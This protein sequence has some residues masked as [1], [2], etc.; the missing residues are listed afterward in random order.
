M[1]AYLTNLLRT[2]QTRTTSMWLGDDLRIS[3]KALGHPITLVCVAGLLLNDHLLK[4]LFSSVLTGKLSDF[5]GIFFFPYIIVAFVAAGTL[6]LARVVSRGHP[7]HISIPFDLSTTAYVVTGLVFSLVKLS[8]QAAAGASALLSGLFKLPIYVAPDPSDLIALLALWPSRWL[9]RSVAH[10]R[11]RQ[12]A[13]G[14]I[15][16]LGMAA[17]AVMATSPCLETPTITHLVRGQDGVYAVLTDFGGPGGILISTDRGLGWEYAH[18]DELPASI[19]QASESQVLLPKIE[20]VPSLDGVCYR[21]AGRGQLEA[22]ADGGSTWETIWSISPSRREYM[23]RV[24]SGHGLLL[25][26]GKE[27]DLRANDLIVVGEAEG[28]L[29]LV[30]IGNEGVLRGRLGSVEWERRGVATVEPTPIRGEL[31]D[32]YLPLIIIGESFA[33]IVAG[34]LAFGLLSAFSWRRL[35]REGLPAPLPKRSLLIAEGIILGLLLLASALFWI[36]LVPVIVLIGVAAPFLWRWWPA[37]RYT[38]IGRRLFWATV[39]GGL[40]VFS[41]AWVPFALWVLGLIPGY[42]AALI[43]ALLSAG[44]AFIWSLRRVRLA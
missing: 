18:P 10:S 17:L 16:S 11:K 39:L 26:C 40:L 27:L 2:K 43:L 9:W 5:F 21:I 33:A 6:A 15:L 1:S 37:A 25:A 4:D 3:L 44:A 24:A 12:P 30:A 7:S 20:C 36:L 35:D 31:V 13:M 8:P 38:I 22:S 34:S 28:H 19:I 14:S 32:L 29:V 23:E 42:S 41:L